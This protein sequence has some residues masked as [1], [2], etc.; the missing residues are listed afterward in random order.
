MQPRL[1]AACYAT[2]RQYPQT[3]TN[4]AAPQDHPALGWRCYFL[5]RR[6]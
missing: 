3:G 2:V 1:P 4:R 5:L 6:W